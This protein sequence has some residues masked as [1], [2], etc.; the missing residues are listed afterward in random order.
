MLKVSCDY[1]GTETP[2]A[3]SFLFG[4]KTVCLP[5]T[6]KLVEECGETLTPA[7]IHRNTDESVCQWCHQELNDGSKDLAFGLPVCDTCNTRMRNFPYPRWIK[8]AFVILIVLGIASFAYNKRHV[9]GF[10]AARKVRQALKANDLETGLRE[11]QKAHQAVPESLEYHFLALLLETQ[12]LILHEKGTEALAKARTIQQLI[13]GQNPVIQSIVS[14]A[15]IA[16][17]FDR[18]DFAQFLD[19][20]KRVHESA[21]NDRQSQ[22]QLASAYSCQYV[23]TGDEEFKNEATALLEKLGPMQDEFE[24]DYLERIQFRLTERRILSTQQFKQEFPNGWKPKES[25][26]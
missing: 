5:C 26:P 25:Q 14:H 12:D 20:A 1:C 10:L 21:P 2:K 13:P 3:D 22:L 24:K 11:A 8:V 17:A 18:K 4:E 9:D 6:Q 19:L 23:V 7:D 15:E 16:D